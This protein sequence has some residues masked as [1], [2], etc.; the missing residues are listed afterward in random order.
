MRLAAFVVCVMAL[1]IGERTLSIFSLH[2]DTLAQARGRVMDL[3][4]QGVSR[5]SQEIAAASAVLSTL[6]AADTSPGNPTPEQCERLH[7]VLDVAA[8]IETLTLVDTDGGVVCTTAP[9]AVGLDLSGREYFRIAMRGVANLS[10]VRQSYV[11]QTPAIYMAA[12]AL[13]DDGEV[14]SVVIARV[15]ITE[16]F[17]ESFS[18]DL[19]LRSQVLLID[20]SGVVIRAAPD[21]GAMM[22]RNLN[23]TPVVSQTLSQTRG[24]II[25][26]GVDSVLRLYGY[27][28]LPMSNMHLIVGLDM[29]AV[30]REVERATWRAAMTLL[31][32]TVIMLI[33]LWL[34]GETLIVAP[35]LALSR[36]LARFG[37]G[38][39]EGDDGRVV[40]TELAPLASAFEAMAEELT[41]RE[42]A[43]RSANRRL[44]SLASLDPLTGI[45]N[46]RSFDAVFAVQWSTARNLAL[47]MIDIDDFK[48][49]NDHYG[50]V[51]GDRCLNRIAQALAATARGTDVVAR[52]GGEEF[53]I[54]MP[55]ANL[56]AALELAER[57]RAAIG[58]LG[59]EHAPAVDGIVT[60]SI[61]CA[62]CAPVPG[63]HGRDLMMAADRA[64]YAAKQA[65]RNRVC[66]AEAV[67]PGGGRT[68]TVSATARR[69]PAGG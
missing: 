31:V 26:E 68:G 48:P 29:A 8:G 64:L 41:R 1:V 53:A 62:A 60:I 46:R 11:T 58:E 22:G 5:Y 28:R 12:P 7:S 66:A 39:R 59:I 16:L 14:R 24:T 23:N 15:G 44:S 40:I 21:N 52:I 10:S 69:D 67:Q 38:K 33:G 54:L 20:P 42:D 57:L 63:L 19:D 34:V 13:E 47:L 49:Y 3:V 30:T 6:A 50:H 25:A 9:G 35:V 36:R 18:S 17:P 43:L 37:E 27:S 45:A 2:A 51:E 65:G 32:A 56:A 55:D 4:Q 61:G